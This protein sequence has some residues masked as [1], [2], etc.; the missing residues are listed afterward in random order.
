MERINRESPT[1]NKE[2]PTPMNDN[3]FGRI[4]IRRIK[5]MTPLPISP[6][7]TKPPPIQARSLRLFSIALL[8]LGGA[9]TAKEKIPTRIVN[10]MVNEVRE[11]PGVRESGL[12]VG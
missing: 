8:S 1:I 7:T 3:E 6:I 4:S 2:K 10:P 5:S 11:K 9:V 12:F